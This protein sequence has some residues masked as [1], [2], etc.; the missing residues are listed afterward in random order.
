MVRILLETSHVCQH[1]CTR[2]NG[3]P[4]QSHA[5]TQLR[6]NTHDESISNYDG[7]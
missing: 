7:H 6:R 5:G 1:A 2:S 4:V 3:I